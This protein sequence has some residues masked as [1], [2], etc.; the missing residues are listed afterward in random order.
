MPTES[1]PLVEL[2]EARGAIIVGKTNTPEMGAGGD[3]FND[4]FGKT[5][6]PWD[7]GKN[8]G[9]SSGGAAVSLATG[10]VWLS[11]GS[12]L[13]GSL[14]TP[15]AF[16]GVVGLRPSPG[17][18]G[19][20]P[21]A[22][23][24]NTEAVQGPMARSVMDAALFLDAM[25]GYDPRIAI[26][27]EAPQQSFQEAVR[28]PNH[29]CA[30]PIVLIGMDLQPSIRKSMQSFAKPCA[31]SP[32]RELWWMRLARRCLILNR[33]ISRC[34]RCSGRL[35]PGKLPRE[36]QDHFKQTLR[37]NI[38]IGRKLAAEQESTTPSAT[39][40]FST[41]TCRSSLCS[42]MCSLVPRLAVSQGLVEE[43]IPGPL[44]DGSSSTTSSGFAFRFW[45]QPLGPRRY[46]F[47]SAS[48][49]RACPL[50]CS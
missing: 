42:S 19:G 18:C 16:C 20:A 37:D 46:P 24:F 34:A 9:G 5:R 28:R 4:V 41:T 27:I 48:P 7:T 49:N 29:T 31:R 23:A 21:P 12:D 15:A 40:R 26:S 35:S 2:L 36:V 50:G 6:N 32:L 43:G 38:E 10:E 39:A 17:R 22:I 33:P 44:A 1:D 13:A 3:T 30:S 47:P 45:R 8:A 14:R 25:A 11:H